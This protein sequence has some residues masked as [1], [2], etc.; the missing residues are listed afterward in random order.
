MTSGGVSALRLRHGYDLLIE[1]VLRDIRLRYKR[2]V[3]GLAWS[4]LSPLAQ[5]LILRLVFGVL[6]PLDI[7][8]YS[9]F[10][11]TGVLVWNWFQASLVGA[12]GAIVDNRDLVRRPG[13]PVATL[14]AVTVTSHL[15]QFLLALPILVIFLLSDGIGLHASILALPLVIVLQ[16]AFTLG[17]AYAL[18]AVHVTFRDT[19]YLL[20]IALQL[21]FYLT[22]VFYDLTVLPEAYRPFFRWNPIAGLLEAYRGVLLDGRLPSA[23]ALVL[24]AGAAIAA[25]IVG[26]ALFRRSSSHFLE[27]L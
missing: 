6:I 23:D 27:D 22:P 20:N 9:S 13:F 16:F 10:L 19:Q 3:L 12:T 1:L 15:V 26:S 4:A 7:P 18:A 24:P 14:P 11:A 17:L 25:L 8:R 5:F 2:S 21:L